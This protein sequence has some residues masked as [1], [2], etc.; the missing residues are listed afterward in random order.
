MAYQQRIFAAGTVFNVED[1]GVWSFADFNGDGSQ[2]LV[3][4]KTRNTGTGR[5]EVHA[6]RNESRFQEH[7]LAT[8]TVFQIEDNGTWLMQDWT[9][10]GKADLVYIKTRNTG[11]GAVEVH[12]ADAASRYQNFVL[13]TGTCFGCGDDGN[14]IWTMSRKGDLVFIKIRNCGSNMVEYH[15]ASKASNYKQFTQHVVTGFGIEDNGTWCLAPNCD[16]DFVD[17]YYI[18]TRNTGSGMVEVHAVSA[19]SGWKSRLI[20]VPTSFDPEDNGQWLM[21]DFTHQ[22]QPDLV[23]I[24]TRSTGTGKIEVHVVEPQQVVPRTF[25]DS[26]SDVR[27]DPDTP[28][29]LRANLRRNNSS[30]RDASIDLNMFLGNT[31]GKFTWEGSGFQASAR[32]TNIKGSVLSAELCKIDGSWVSDSFDLRNVI[33]NNDGVFQAVNV[34]VLLAIPDEQQA[35]VLNQLQQALALPDVKLKLF[36]EPDGATVL[37]V[38]VGVD[39]EDAFKG[40]FLEGIPIKTYSAEARDSL[41]HL[42]K[43][44]GK[45]IEQVN[46]DVGTI[47]FGGSV[48]AYT[49]VEAGVSLIKAQASCFDLNLGYGVDTGIGYRD[50]SYEMKLD[51]W[52]FQIGRKVSISVFGSSFGIDFGRLFG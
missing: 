41:M 52:G 43:S 49:G 32:G 42:V 44:S 5:I 47:A 19:S 6:A 8:G 40:T 30:W 46:V 31:D 45:P 3:Y 2:D 13:Q 9:G 36:D 14:G 23:Y 12:V 51:G 11:T 10:D 15:V 50:G 48:G 28:N 1:N 34:P 27:L 26:S 35:I 37:Y 25:M 33:M 17:L 39:T 22:K 38:N 29:V 20:D 21:V 7:T 18:K 4:I 24:K 16:G